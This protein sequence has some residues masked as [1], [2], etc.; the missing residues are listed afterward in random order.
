VTPEAD[1]VE[2]CVEVGVEVVIVLGDEL[3]VEDELSDVLVEVLKVVGGSV[4]MELE[5]ELELVED[6]VLEPF[7]A[8]RA[9][10]PPTT[11][12]MIITT[13]TIP[14]V[15]EIPCLR[16]RIAPAICSGYKKGYRICK[17]KFRISFSHSVRAL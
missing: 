4:V 5:E 17:R 16:T 7:P 15:R 2:V 6:V 14:T 1:V 3:A 9:A 13:T 11:M 10:A 8:R 12:I